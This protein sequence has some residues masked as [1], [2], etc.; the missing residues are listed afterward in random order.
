[1]PADKR[2][3][4]LFK[5]RGW[6]D[7]YAMDEGTLEWTKSRLRRSIRERLRAA[8]D[9][10]LAAVSA[11]L[12][13]GLQTAAEAWR[14]PGTVALFGGLRGE[15]DLVL[16]LLPWLRTRGWRTVL[17][18]VEGDH[19]RPADVLTPKDCRR[20]VHDVWEPAPGCRAVAPEALDVILVPGLAFGVADGSRLG[21][22]GGFYDRFLATPGLRARRIGVAGEWQV[23]DRVPCEAHDVRVHELVTEAQHRILEPA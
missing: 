20:G 2:E 7:G 5:C 22:G 15:P 18:A 11:G 21:R 9:A 13:V 8:S 17:F 3:V 14:A 4:P 23:L 12:R 6:G 1:M 10:E 16:G 19:L